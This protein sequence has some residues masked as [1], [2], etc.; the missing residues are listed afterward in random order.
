MFVKECNEIFA[1]YYKVEATNNKSH[2][3]IKAFNHSSVGGVVES[4]PSKRRTLFGVVQHS[5]LGKFKQHLSR[6]RFQLHTTDDKG[7]E[8]YKNGQHTLVISPKKSK[9]I[10]P[11]SKL[12]IHFHD[13]SGEI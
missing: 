2:P 6:I 4:T 3:I 10:S 8:I 13:I 7:Q 1:E 5:D 11:K 12:D 9:R